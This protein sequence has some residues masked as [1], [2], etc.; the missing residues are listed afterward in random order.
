MIFFAAMPWKE[1]MTAI[2]IPGEAIVLE[3]VWQQ[4]SAPGAVVAPPHPEYGGSLDNPVVS[5][6]AHAL[7]RA[8]HAS[9]RF[10]WRGVGASQGIVTGEVGFAERDY[11]AALEHMEATLPGGVIAAGYSF[12][13]VAALRLALRDRRI[14]RLVLVAPPAAMLEDLALGDLAI[15]VRVIVG[16]RD[17]FAPL[18]ALEAVLGDVPD[19]RIDVIPGAD[20]FFALRGVAEIGVL[21]REALA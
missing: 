3:G 7:Y 10:H 20:H 16:Q 17:A 19:V 14:L 15:P 6:I 5:E 11:R 8:G 21:V 1:Q 13:A 9:I 12:G 4:G 18:S 2:A